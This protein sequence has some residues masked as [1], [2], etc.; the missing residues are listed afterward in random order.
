MR[1]SVLAVVGRFCPENNKEISFYSEQR[2]MRNKSVD[3]IGRLWFMGKNHGA[4]AQLGSPSAPPNDHPAVSGKIHEA[5]FQQWRAGF[6]FP[7]TSPE[8][9][10]PWNHPRQCCCRILA[11]DDV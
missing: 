11:L 5:R 3:E 10:S 9:Y 7:L 4:V 1:T 8:N 2:P 6:L